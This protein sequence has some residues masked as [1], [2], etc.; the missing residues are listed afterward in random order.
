MKVTKH[1]KI[2]FVISV[3]FIDEVELDVA[4]LYVCGIMFGSLYMYIWEAI[5]MWRVNQ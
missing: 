5:F 3:D 4:P 1:C 2:K